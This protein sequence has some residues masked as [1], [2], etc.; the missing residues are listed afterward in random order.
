LASVCGVSTH[1]QRELI[2]AL[3]AADQRDMVAYGD[4]APTLR[5][6][7]EAGITVAVCSNWGWEIDPYLEQVGLL[8]LVDVA[9]TSA[10]AGARKPHPRMYAVTVDAVAVDPG[11]IVF[12]GDSWG[13]DVLG[14]R[15][16]GMAA[17]HI[18]REEDRP[19]EMPPS[20]DDGVRRVSD[21]QEVLDLFAIS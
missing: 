17:V 4:A 10:R 5:A 15:A 21:L 19:G 16:A 8:P 7:R 11:D 18:W 1:H 20:L 12:I 9:I 14:P 3:R 6:L 13:P 2:D